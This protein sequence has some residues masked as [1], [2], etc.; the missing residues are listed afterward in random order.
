MPPLVVKND[1][2]KEPRLLTSE[3]MASVA[4]DPNTLSFERPADNLANMREPELATLLFKGFWHAVSEALVRGGHLGPGT[5]AVGYLVTSQRYSMPL[6]E[7]FHSNCVKEGPV[8]FVASVHEAAALVIGAFRADVFQPD[9]NSLPRAN[10]VCLVVACDERS[11]DIVCFDFLQATPAHH[12]I[13][14]RDC[15]QTTAAGLSRRLHD[16]DWLG[17][18]SLLVIVED[19]GLPPSVRTSIDA[20][21]QALADT[22]VIQRSQLVAASGLKL[23]GGAHIAMCAAKRAPDQE[24]YEI[25]HACHVG[26][27]VDQE[28]FKPI[29]NKYA[30]DHMG[31][32]PY[33]AV[34]PFQ[35]RGQPGNNLRLNFYSGYSTRVADAVPLGNTVLWGDDL[36]ELNE[37]T[38]LTAA[39]R[40]DAP[41]GGEFL[42]GIMP[43]NRLLRRQAFALPGLMV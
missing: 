5:Q 10:T 17:A 29:V 9:E 39:I 26:L 15:F 30:W 1:P 22:A 34:Q 2:L 27:Q 13:L 42:I 40:F 18:F 20:P 6:L 35:F 31:D 24:E 36:T 43:E 4:A 32:L 7:S 19:P 41:N 25:A 14:I 11:I 38:A 16:C 8:K 28:H 12:R 33:L 21:L 37:G 3:E 23:R